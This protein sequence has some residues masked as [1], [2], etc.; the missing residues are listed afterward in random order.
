M[1]FLQKMS[2]PQLVKS[3]LALFFLVFLFFSGSQVVSEDEMVPIWNIR[4]LIQQIQVQGQKEAFLLEE[5]S[6]GG[7][8]WENPLVVLDPY[9]V[10]PLSALIFFSSEQP[11]RVSLQLPGKNGGQDV[12]FSSNAFSEEHLLPVFGL[13]PGETNHLLL[14]GISQS[15][16]K[17]EKEIQ[18][19]TESLSGKLENLLLSVSQGDPSRIQ[20]GF[21]FLFEDD[22]KV[23]F[24]ENGEIRWV[25]AL[26]TLQPVLYDTRNGKKWFCTGNYHFGDVIIWEVSLLGRI[27]RVYYSPYGVHHDFAFLENGNLVLLG[28]ENG[29]TIE[30]LVYEIDVDTGEIVFELDM[31]TVLDPAREAPGSFPRDWLHLN[32]LEVVSG[33]NSLILS[34]RHQSALIKMGYPSGEIEWILGFPEGWDNSL[35]SKLLTPT[36]DD[37]EWPFTQHSPQILPDWDRKPNTMDLMVFDNGYG[38]FHRHFDE[39]EEKKLLE[40]P[41]REYSRVVHY[42][43]DEQERTVEQVWQFGKGDLELFSDS[44]GDGNVLENGN[45]LSAF[46]VSNRPYTGVFLE[47]A[48]ESNEVVWQVEWGNDVYCIERLPLYGSFDAVFSL[49]DPVDNFIPE[50]VIGKYVQE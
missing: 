8:S 39:R 46:N 35:A 20:E 9:G 47:I 19:P 2:F 7:Y 22:P 11:I 6:S 33:E 16:E 3:V 24:D 38:R 5:I 45:V 17:W 49:G 48:P 4:S 40:N 32:A 23:A 27:S 30:D 34:A 36:G 13:F 1:G 15:G 43:V 10:S 31:K 50:E 29:P 14:Q 18:I 26:P 12:V 25:L 44:R 21:N 42:R 28:S 37:F 41:W